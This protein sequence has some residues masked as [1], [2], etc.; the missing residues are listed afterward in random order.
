MTTHRSVCDIR[1]RS[2]CRIECGR[3]FVKAFL[4]ARSRRGRHTVVR[5]GSSL[6][7]TVVTTS[8]SDGRR[9]AFVATAAAAP[10]T[11]ATSWLRGRRLVASVGVRH[12]CVCN[13]E[14]MAGAAC[15]ELLLLQ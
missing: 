8:L 7:V 15:R 12:L 10:V 13:L 3:L 1:R 14:E 5:R 11:V 4:T 9:K 2:D 6:F